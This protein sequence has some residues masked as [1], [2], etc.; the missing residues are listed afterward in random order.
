MRCYQKV[1]GPICFGEIHSIR[2]FVSLSFALIEGH[3]ECKKHAVMLGCLC[4][5]LLSEGGAT[6]LQNGET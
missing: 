5:A 3:R 2:I 1:L 4:K 6:L